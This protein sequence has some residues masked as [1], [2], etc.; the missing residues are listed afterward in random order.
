MS[1][2]SVLLQCRDTGDQLILS[3]L[4]ESWIGLI[5]REIVHHLQASTRRVSFWHTDLIFP[6]SLECFL[7]RRTE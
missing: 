7:L 1:A 4:V 2:D 3:S 6:Q 5:T